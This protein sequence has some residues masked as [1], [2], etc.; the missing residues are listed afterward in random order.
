MQDARRSRSR[1]SPWRHFAL[2][3]R[4]A[5]GGATRE[6]TRLWMSTQLRGKAT[7]EPRKRE[8]TQHKPLQAKAGKGE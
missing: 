8:P 2:G 5:A 1:S 4:P 3:R 6:S 7:K